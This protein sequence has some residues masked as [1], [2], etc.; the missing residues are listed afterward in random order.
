MNN[1]NEAL[2]KYAD[3][4]IIIEK[5]DNKSAKAAL[6]NSRGLSY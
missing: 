4:L 6:L 2:K 1:N 5:I 3:G